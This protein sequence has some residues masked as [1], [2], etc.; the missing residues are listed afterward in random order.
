MEQKHP[1]VARKRRGNW[2][3]SSCVPS[4]SSSSTLSPTSLISCL[5]FARRKHVSGLLCSIILGEDAG[6]HMA[7]F[8]P[9]NCPLSS[10]P[11]AALGR[12]HMLHSRC[13]G[14]FLSL[15]CW[16]SQSPHLLPQLPKESHCSTA[17]GVFPAS[18]TCPCS[19]L[20]SLCFLKGVDEAR[21]P[22]CFQPL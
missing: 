5:R 15:L 20:D 14:T 2:V 7:G 3:A 6:T 13:A 4:S 16:V 18:A 22:Q 9:V 11:A 21:C 1:S 19:P 12:L 10:P 17:I 8:L